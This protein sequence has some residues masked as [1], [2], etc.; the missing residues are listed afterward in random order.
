MTMQGRKTG[1]SVP[2]LL[3]ALL[4]TP[5]LGLVGCASTPESGHSGAANRA[6][7]TTPIWVTNPPVQ[8]GMAYG[9]GSIEALG[10]ETAAVRRAGEL[11]RLDLVSQLRVTVSGS[12]LQDS[13]EYRSSGEETRVQQSMR[14]LA[15]SQVPEVE[16]DELRIA[17]SDVYNG[18]AYALAELD[19]DAAA[20][21]MRRGIAE[22]D[23]QL[24]AYRL[25]A[26]SGV[27]G[28]VLERLRELLPAVQLFAK[29]DAIAAKMAL[30]SRDHHAPAAD[31]DLVLLQQRIYDLIG[32]VR[33]VLVCRDNGA[34]AVESSVLEALTRQGM[35]VASSG[36][37]D[38][39]FEL[40]VESDSQLTQ[41]SYYAFLNTRIIIRDNNGRALSSL[42]V[43]A[44]GVSGIES[45]ARQKAAEAVANRLGDELA[46]TLTERL[47]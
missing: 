38:L 32:E 45:V 34:R 23:E 19:R 4:L 18:Y 28:P 15:R 36:S 10:D 20:S 12:V 24:E 17:D 35:K 33:V 47:R 13:S 40:D 21:R 8:E 42:S 37:G 14:L 25:L 46:K 1:L 41:G 5:S 29:R 9:V 22:I 26:D 27:S 31:T 39:F 30:V 7:L 16:L 43:R 44:R 2:A 6:N 3:L 11:A